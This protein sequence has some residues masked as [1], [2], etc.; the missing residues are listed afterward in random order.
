MA[1]ADRL[2]RGAGVAVDGGVG[3]GARGRSKGLDGAVELRRG[4]LAELLANGANEGKGARGGGG[5]KWLRNVRVG[6]RGT[7]EAA[8]LRG[9]NGRSGSARTKELSALKGRRG[10]RRDGDQQLH[11]AQ[12]ELSVE[13][14]EGGGGAEEHH[15]VLEVR[16][17]GGEGGEAS[18]RVV[19]VGFDRVGDREKRL[20]RLLQRVRN[21]LDGDG[22]HS[23][24]VHQLKRAEER[25][26]GH[27]VGEG[28]LDVGV[29]EI[30]GGG[31]A[32][33]AEDGGAGVVLEE[34]GD[35]LAVVGDVGEGNLI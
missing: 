3:G 33:G 16:L 12:N 34:V 21:V 10:A 7:C 20:Q 8:A 35:G 9:R 25:G 5:H 22:G 19:A 14:A 26:G 2:R 6:R 29:D 11:E 27:R 28:Q 32:E 1:G 31:A 4:G 18:R 24:A 17:G 13:A 23:V 30:I 15:G